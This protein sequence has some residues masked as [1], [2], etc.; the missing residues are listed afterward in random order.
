MYNILTSV[1][2][3]QKSCLRS[4][5]AI[6]SKIMNPGNDDINNKKYVIRSE[7]DV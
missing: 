7:T 3:A 1:S 6:S 2:T 5:T 4:C